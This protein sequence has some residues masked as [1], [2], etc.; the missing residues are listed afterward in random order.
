MKINKLLSAFTILASSLFLASCNNGDP[1]Q[2]Q[3]Q[4]IVFV[5]YDGITDGMHKFAYTEP[6]QNNSIN[7]LS[8]VNFNDT[9][10][11][12]GTRVI[13]VFTVPY[14]IEIK[15]N[16]N[17]DC[18]GIGALSAFGTMQTAEI[19]TGATQ[20]DPFYL[21]SVSR[22][23]HYIDVTGLASA[24]KSKMKL[25]ADEKTLSTNTPTLYLVYE[26]ETPGQVENG[27][28]FASFDISAITSNPAYKGFNLYVHNSNGDS[29]FPFTLQK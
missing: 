4:A 22:A 5:D 3:Y 29:S 25:V 6:N 21:T 26:L 23:G 13:G 9:P 18:V 8:Q 17:L 24:E 2:D 11:A 15:N 19:T 27:Q 28:F 14:G 20:G 7:I 1:S 12:I 16:V 10:P